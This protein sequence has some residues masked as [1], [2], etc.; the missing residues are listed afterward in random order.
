M[1]SA[2]ADRARPAHDMGPRGRPPRGPRRYRS[3]T[4]ACDVSHGAGLLSSLTWGCA[5]AF[6]RRGVWRILAIP[7]P[8]AILRRILLLSRAFGRDCTNHA[9]R[10]PPKDP[11]HRRGVV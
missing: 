5:Q 4:G 9:D 6:R 8:I 2:L 1:R 10:R 7:L 3:A 11:V